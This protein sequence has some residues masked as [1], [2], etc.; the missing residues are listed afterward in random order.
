MAAVQDVFGFWT[1]WELC[2]S[3]TKGRKQS[4]VTW[5]MLGTLW[6]AFLCA[7]VQLVKQTAA[8][9]K[10]ALYGAQVEGHLESLQPIVLSL[11]LEDTTSLGCINRD[12]T[13]QV[14]SSSIQIPRNKKSVIISIQTLFMSIWRHFCFSFPTV[15][16][17]LFCLCVFVSQSVLRRSLSQ[18]LYL[19]PLS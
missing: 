16:N 17:Q 8:V 19:I 4:T 5:A 7:T 6:S 15:Y 12:F 18:P 9:C 13:L 1:Q 14:W 2:S 3:S 11:R 10:D